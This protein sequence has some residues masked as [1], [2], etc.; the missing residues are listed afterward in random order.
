MQEA[1][2]KLPHM[3]RHSIRSTT[4]IL[5]G[6]VVN[7]DNDNDMQNHGGSTEQDN[8][9]EVVPSNIYDTTGTSAWGDVA[10]G[11]TATVPVGI[12]IA[13]RH[14]Q[15]KG[16]FDEKMLRTTGAPD[17]DGSNKKIKQ[18]GHGTTAPSEKH[19]S[20][21]KFDE[22]ETRIIK[23]GSS[24]FQVFLE[25]AA[26]YFMCLI[27]PTALGYLYN[28]YDA[29]RY[30]PEVRE[31][32]DDQGDSYLYQ[33]L[34]NYQWFMSSV[35]DPVESYMCDDDG[36]SASY[37]WSLVYSV[38]ART[39]LCPVPELDSADQKRSV[40][41]DDVSAKSDV[42]TIAVCSCLLAAIRIAIVRYTVPMED[43][44]KVEAMVRVKSDHFLR[45][46]YML[47]PDGTPLQKKMIHGF[48]S[49]NT[50]V[51]LQLPNLHDVEPVEM[52]EDEMFGVHIDATEHEDDL[53]ME[54]LRQFRTFN[55]QNENRTDLMASDEL[56]FPL[57]AVDP[58]VGSKKRL[59]AAPRYATALFRLLYSTVTA[60]IALIY[61][62]GANFWPW[63]VMGHGSTVKCW[64][65]SGGM[66]V[67]MDSDFDQV[68]SAVHGIDHSAAAC[69]VLLCSH[70]F[71]TFLFNQTS[72][73]QC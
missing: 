51:G 50:R 66:S 52:S 19:K 54:P 10:Q 70:H 56:Q 49:N 8:V 5:K 39:N 27:L 35:Y 73:M 4:S 59:Y 18:E 36:S 62:R 26:I 61:F 43:A 65:L 11:D 72:A 63:Y 13:Y 30:E 45:S 23:K 25:S 38:V 6:S 14:Q 2:T 28:W 34:A 31:R 32:V 48:S 69:G 44:D 41:S 12:T 37:A 42:V 68:G 64:D 46:N 9:T 29:W 21:K 7:N 3:R 20:K 57:S 47:S 71:I 33:Y 24:S 58:S 17:G 1:P 67:G 22:A 55:K 16:V 40:L 60:G 15:K 53:A